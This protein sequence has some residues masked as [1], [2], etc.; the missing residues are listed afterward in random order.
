MVLASGAQILWY[1]S[2]LP[3]RLASHFD[4]A[5][6]PN[7]YMSK[8]TFFG[9][10]LAAIGVLTAVFLLLPALLRYVPSSLINLPNKDY[11][12]APER[13]KETLA[14]LS[15]RLT[16]FG[17][18]TLALLAIVM[19]LVIRANLPGSDG[20]L[21]S[22]PMWILLGAYAVFLIL[23]LIPTITHYSRKN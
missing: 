23:W 17:A 8:T 2:R 4:G 19:E 21:P 12:L 22:K 11:W 15:G 7:G 6:N 16:G 1:Q 10:H 5:G 9:F 3:E 13:R 20:K 18:V 14:H